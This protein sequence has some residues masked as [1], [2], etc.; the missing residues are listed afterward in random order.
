MT[1]VICGGIGYNCYKSTIIAETIEVILSDV[2][3]GEDGGGRG[4]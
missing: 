1:V 3:V 2:I 4:C